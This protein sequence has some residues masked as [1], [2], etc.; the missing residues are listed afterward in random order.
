[1]VLLTEEN[2][3]VGDIVLKSKETAAYIALFILQF[4]SA[5]CDNIVNTNRICYDHPCM[6]LL[7]S[8]T[9]IFCKTKKSFQ[10]EP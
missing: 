5:I 7:A 9:E 10:H 1:M 6:F 4:D 8:L 2:F 3:I